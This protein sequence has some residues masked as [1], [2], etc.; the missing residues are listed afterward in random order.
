MPGRRRP[1]ERRLRGHDKYRKHSKCPGAAVVAPR[2][3]GYAG[4]ARY[5]MTGAAGRPGGP[6]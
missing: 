3:P 1:W 2:K 4:G 6:V 5:R